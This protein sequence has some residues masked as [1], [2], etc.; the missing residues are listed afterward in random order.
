MQNLVSYN[1]KIGTVYT[2][3]NWAKWL[4]EKGDVYSK[5]LMGS[6]VCDPTAGTGVFILQLLEKA[7]SEG[8]KLNKKLLGN[9]GY[10]ELDPAAH[11]IF[12]H[13]LQK[14]VGKLS[15]YIQIYNTDL[16]LETPKAEFDILVGN[17]P[18]ANFCDLSNAYKEKIKEKFIEQGLV[19]DNRSVLLGS[20]RIDLAALAINFAMGRLLSPSGTAYFYLPTSLYYGDNAHKGWRTFTTNG[21]NFATTWLYEFDKTKIFTGVSTSYCAAAFEMDKI[22]KFP[23]K[24][25]KEQGSPL[26]WRATW[27]HPLR[28]PDD[29][30]IEKGTNFSLSS[31]K[32]KILHHQTPRQG[33]NTCGANAIFIFNDYPSFIPPEIVFPLMTKEIFTGIESSP[34][35]WIMLPYDPIT[36]KPLSWSQIKNYPDLAKYLLRHKKEL[37]VRKGTLIRSPI[38]KGHWWSLLGVGPYSFAPYKV[39]WQS[40]GKKSFSPLIVS[41][42]KKMPWQGNQAMHAFIPCWN[43][44]DAKRIINALKNPIIEKTLRLMN[45]EGKRNWAQ[46]GKIKK[47]LSLNEPPQEQRKF[48]QGFEQPQPPA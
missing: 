22:Q 38:E 16:I 28:D 1:R 42:Y 17:P 8:V 39:M 45:G 2:P 25:F 37:Q 15:K 6:R 40:Y 10:I 30:W 18:W 20:S 5:W 12:L 11:A 21:R 43:S 48:F 4:L 27:L 13:S 41:S 19:T 35:K 46:P 14:A 9:L 44:Q 29:Q 24:C 47:I 33:I 36:A 26:D 34:L 3:S 31:I 23:V 32:L 7:I